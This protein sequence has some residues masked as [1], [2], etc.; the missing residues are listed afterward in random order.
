MPSHAKPRRNP[1]ARKPAVLIAAFLATPRR[2][3][4]AVVAVAIAGP[5]LA[6][7][8]ALPANA[9]VP[10]H[11]AWESSAPKGQWNTGAFDLFN[12]EWNT[13]AFGPQTI[14]GFSHSHWGVQSTQPGSTSVK[15][16]PSVQQLYKNTTLGSLRGLWSHFSESMPAQANFDAEAAYDIWLN[17]FSIEVM[18]WVDNHGQRPAG[19][20]IGSTTIFGQKFSVWQGNSHFFT[21]ELSGKQETKGTAHLLKSMDWL[22]HHG[23]LSS[24]DTLTQVNFGWEICSTDGRPMD[25]T[26]T[27]YTL[28]T[29]R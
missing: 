14:W 6:V 15:T 11:P 21:L 1:K 13:G 22:V 18:V 23:Y 5:A 12:N 27:N 8:A 24:S 16:Y 17:K 2:K 20:I 10:A 29:K 28:T 4:A 7:S 25:F 3:L 9:A 26:M 19:H